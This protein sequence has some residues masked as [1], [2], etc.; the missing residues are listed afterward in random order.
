MI[1]PH[2]CIIDQNVKLPKMRCGLL[3]GSLY[4]SPGQEWIDNGGRMMRS[5]HIPGAVHQHSVLNLNPADWTYLDPEDL[6]TRA[7][8][9]GIRPEQRL[10]TYCGVGISASLE[11]FSLYLAGYRNLALYDG[12]WEEWGTDPARPVE[13]EKPE[14][15]E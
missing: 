2:T 1:R 11:L 13:R 14:S 15:Q 3:N 8:A 7:Q 9:A 10:I 6:S 4:L 5:G 12:S